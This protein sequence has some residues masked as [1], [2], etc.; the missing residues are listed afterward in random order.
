MLTRECRHELLQHLFVVGHAD[1]RELD[2]R[3]LRHLKKSI[4]EGVIKSSFL[5]FTQFNV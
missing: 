2:G 1:G 4:R 3:R 5:F